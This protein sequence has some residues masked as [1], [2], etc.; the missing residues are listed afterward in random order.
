MTPKIR[1]FLE[2]HNLNIDEIKYIIRENGSTVIYTVDDRTVETFLPVKDFREALPTEKLLHPNKGIIANASQI[3][4]VADGRYLMADG[5]SF[6][7]RVHNSQLHDTRLLLLGM[8]F[9][10]S[11]TAPS[12]DPP[13]D[14]IFHK[15]TVFDHMPLPMYI[16]ELHMKETEFGADF[17]FRYGNKAMLELEDMKLDEIVGREFY[18][19]IPTADPKRLVVYMDVA[20]NGSSRTLR[21]Y[22][23]SK[24]GIITVSAF[25]PLP[26]Y[27]ACMLMKVEPVDPDH[28]DILEIAKIS[29]GYAI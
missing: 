9:E 21:E 23:P 3:V 15:F 18:D 16:V 10:H 4:D 12:E 19:I 17:I 27:C 25:Q 2:K 6:K 7:Y 8:Q 29:E 1:K 20:L 22:D 28:E 5:R 13:P 26:G 24:N 11:R 14:D